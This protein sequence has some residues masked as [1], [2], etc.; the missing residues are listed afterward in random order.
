MT[1]QH[2][3]LFGDQTVDLVPSLHRLLSISQSSQTVR[4]FLQSTLDVIQTRISSLGSDER[5]QIGHFDSFDGL[6]QRYSGSEDTIGVIHTVVICACRLAELLLLVENDPSLLG[7]S[8]KVTA[9]GLCTGLLPAAALAGSHNITELILISTETIAICFR[10]ALELYRRTRRI[11]E[12][13]GHWA[14]TVL[15]VPVQEM[16][17]ILREFHDSVVFTG[18][19]DDSWLTLFGPPPEL[20]QLFSYSAKIEAAP[21][22]KLAAYGAVHSPHLPLP[23]LEAVVGKSHILSRSIQSNVQVLCTSTGIPY[24][25]STLRDLYLS[26]CREI[27]SS[28]LKMGTALRAAAQGL[29][30]NIPVRLNVIGLT[31]A[32]P[33]VKRVLDSHKLSVTLHDKPAALSE[34]SEDL[35]DGSN[36]IAIVG[37]AGRFPGSESLEEFWQ[38]LMDGLDAHQEIPND[39]FDIE[40]FYDPTGRNKNSL[41]TRYGCFLRNPGEFDHRLFNV[42]P[43]EAEQMSPLQRLLLMSAYEALQ[44]SG[45]TSNGT[46]STQSQRIATYFGQAADDWKDGSRIAGIDLYYVPGL[47]RGFTPGRLNYHYKWEGASY[48]VDSACASSASAIGLAC[49]ALLSRECDTA[50]AGGVN[51]ITSPE[52]YSGLSKGSFL[53]PTG[54]CKTFQDAAD[55]YCRGEAVGVLVLKRLEDALH[56]NDNVLA[57]IRGHGRNHSAHAS[58]ITHPHAETQVRLY[59]DVLRKAGVQAEEVG[60]VEMHG[61][62]TQAGDAVE[63]SSVLEVFG[64]N[65]PKTNPLIVGAVKANLGHTEAAAGVVSMIKS[66]MALQKGV[67][68]PQPGVPFKINHNY[69]PLKELNVR[70]ADDKINFHKPSGGNGKRKVMINNFDAAGGNSCFIIEEAPQTG[71]K[72]QDPRSHHAVAVSARTSLSLK[73]NK[74]ALLEYLTAHAE[75]SLADLAYSTTARRIHEELRVAYSGDSVESIVQHLGRDLSKPAAAQRGPQKKSLVWVFSGQGS[76]YPGM[77]SELFHTNATFRN[78]IRSMQRICDAQ[79]LPSFEDL[80]S[81]RDVAVTQKTTVQV[82]LAVVAIELALA[83]LWRCWGVKPDVVIGHS[84]GEYAALCVSGVLSVNDVLHLVGRRAMLT[85]DRCAEGTYAMLAVVAPA[86][87]LEEY[88]RRPEYQS[89][90]ISCYNSPSAT[91]VSGPVSELQNLE[92][93]MRAAGS[94]CTLIRVPYGFHSPQMDSILDDFER[95]A[96]TVRFQVPKIPIVST[97]TGSIVRESGYITPQYLARHAREPVEFYKAL[98]ACRVEGVAD[99]HTIWLELGPDSVCGSMVKATLGA[100]NVHGSIKSRESNWKT[101]SATVA[102]LY[103]AGA[104]FNWCDFHHEYTKSLRLLDLPKYA[105]DTKNFWRVYKEDPVNQ[106]ENTMTKPATE[107]HISSSL[108]SIKEQVATTDKIRIVFETSLADPDLYEAIRGHQVDE[109]PLCPSGVFCD[110]ALSAAKHVYSKVDKKDGGQKHLQIRNLELNHPVVASGD[111][112]Q[113]LQI[114]A[115]REARTGHQ[116]K[117]TFHLHDGSSLQEIGGCRVN[118]YTPQEWEND[119]SKTSFFVKSRMDSLVESVKA[120]R[121]D[122]LRRSVIYKL[123]ASL[124]TYDPKYQAIEEMFWDEQSN[125]AVANISL[126][127]YN[128]R[129]HFECLPYWTDPLVHLAGFVLNVNLTSASDDVWLSSGVTRMQLHEELSTDT[130]YVSYVHSH[131]PDE[132]DVSLSDVYVFNEKGLVGFCSLVFQKMP[133]IVLHRLLHKHES[134]APAKGSG[135]T[136]AV[137]APKTQKPVADN[138]EL[139]VTT[140]ETASVV[141]ENNL[142]DRLIAIIAEETGV[143]MLDMVPTADFASMGVDSLMG[144][145]IIDRVQKELDVQLEASFFQENL[146]VADAQRAL[147]YDEADSESDQAANAGSED[148]SPS[149]GWT[150]ISPPESD[151]EDIIVT[152]NKLSE[153]IQ[154]ATEAPLTP[155]AEVVTQ[156]ALV[157]ITPPTAPSPTE[158]K[159]NVVLIHGRKKSNKTPLFLITDGA[160]SATAYIHLPRFASGMP[161]YAVESPFVRCPLEY[162]FSVEETAKMYIAAIKKIQPEGPYMLGG[163]SA[164]G[165]H[166]FEVSRQLL[167][168][169]DKIKRLVIIDMKIPKPMPEGLE[170]TMDFL[171]K[172]GLTTGINRAGPAL[173][174]MSERLKQHLASTIKSLMYYTAPVMDPSRR[175]EKS[176]IIWAEYGLAEIIG[177]AAFKDVAEMMGLKEDVDGNPME[178]DTGL[179]SWFYS[180]RDNFGPNGW[181]KLLGSVVCRSMKAD[182]FSM[183]TPPAANELGKL[184]QE[185]VNE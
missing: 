179:A 128:G 156:P 132:H 97:V 95:L 9:L 155:P 161:L 43:R 173:A 50:L 108:H 148:D 67:I 143:D 160:G 120:G 127:P 22:L 169:G 181:D 62:G 138:H 33:I 99:A 52:P 75:I 130:Q 12:T 64:R 122:H 41:S 180:R 152:P 98:A 126:K 123:F 167:E 45:Y 34:Q 47:Q 157:E 151:I 94:V 76:Q 84:L 113:T 86:Q 60:F 46:L 150:P 1:T 56:D 69:P 48:S 53:S 16:D 109:L 71:S 57:V 21:K 49:S 70:I 79:G 59:N 68:P 4:R 116:V 114:S 35:R 14:Y 131:A 91:V 11:E 168:A 172:V 124:V 36:A 163:W 32:T 15:G 37:M 175:P 112:K 61:T 137:A 101:I 149:G 139:P 102:A 74:E 38:S 13:P 185:A 182:H 8:S 73:K 174:G 81:D 121:G 145:T 85:Q 142:A 154:I 58:S 119:W 90:C 3:L 107:K 54:G 55:G 125:D 176:Y 29:Q 40:A 135:L 31:Q 115:E 83:D 24:S 105:F 159:S 42:S 27:V 184:L 111:P 158:Y 92:Q 2:F 140:P 44:M 28:R 39:R 7:S 100:M 166:A 129:G 26:V 89:C 10:L 78:S 170:V 147:G 96:Q 146:T 87:A 133:R 178:D 93:S 136:H 65:R 162:N 5:A 171:D 51:S 82:Q 104:G 23:D 19:E 118:T 66:I 153:A 164:G 6:L 117:I 17:D 103:T 80:I 77:G 25:A 63:M 183:V 141:V 88:L 106:A 134:R 20:E 72:Q 177:D 165:A 30:C 144:I 110:I 18:V